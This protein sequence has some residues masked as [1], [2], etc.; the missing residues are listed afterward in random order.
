MLPKITFT[1]L[2]KFLAQRT[3]QRLS[4]LRCLSRGYCANLNNGYFELVKK[5]I[6]KSKLLEPSEVNLKNRRV[7]TVPSRKKEL[8]VFSVLWEIILVTIRILVITTVAFG[9]LS[10]YGITRFLGLK[11]FPVIYLKGA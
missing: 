8:G 7:E 3:F 5:A 11:T 6:S 9:L 10:F 1:L 4:K 2:S